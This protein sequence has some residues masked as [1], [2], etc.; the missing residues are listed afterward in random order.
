MCR[1]CQHYLSARFAAAATIA[2]ATAAIA[3]HLLRE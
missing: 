1:G 3:Q 2:A